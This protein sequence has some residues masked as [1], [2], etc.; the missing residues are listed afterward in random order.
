MIRREIGN[1]QRKLRDASGSRDADAVRDI[2]RSILT[3]STRGVDMSPLYGDVIMVCRK[4]D[5]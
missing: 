4:R 2:M 1:Y 3:Q 5:R